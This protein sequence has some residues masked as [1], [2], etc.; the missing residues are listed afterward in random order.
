MHWPA[1]GKGKFW[2]CVIL[3]EGEGGWEG[4]GA[5]DEILIE[6]AH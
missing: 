4:D 2:K 5:H 6:A 3:P 1:K